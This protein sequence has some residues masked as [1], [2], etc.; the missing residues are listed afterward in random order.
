MLQYKLLGRLQTGNNEVGEIQTG[1]AT[2]ELCGF[3][4]DMRKKK[5][6]SDFGHEKVDLV[7]FIVVSYPVHDQ[8]QSFIDQT[9]KTQQATKST[10]VYN[11]SFCSELGLYT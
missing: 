3:T 9:C 5:I 4:G 8:R 10:T 2:G 11:V 6:W 1:K 7:K